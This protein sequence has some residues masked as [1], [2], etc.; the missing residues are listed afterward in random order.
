MVE[1][2]DKPLK[3]GIPLLNAYV[4]LTNAGIEIK[5]RGSRREGLHISWGDVIVNAELPANRPAKISTAI[6]Y[7]TWVAG[8]KRPQKRHSRRP[9]LMGIGRHA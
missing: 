3:R 8:K 4:N 6:E 1:L 9:A 2:T 5:V 7:L